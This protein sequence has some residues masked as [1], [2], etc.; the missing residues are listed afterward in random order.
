MTPGSS[1]VLVVG[2][3]NV[4]GS[5][6]R[7]WTTKT[8]IAD[9][10]NELSDQLGGCVW[11]SQI[12]EEWSGELSRGASEEVGRPDPSKVRVVAV[13]LDGGGLASLWL[14]L[15]RELLRSRYAIF[16]LPASLKLVPVLPLA[17]L[18]VRRMA[19]YVAGDF[20][21]LLE[22]E[23][24]GRRTLRGRVYRSAFRTAIAVSHRV[25]ARGRYLAAVSRR[26][27][28]HVFETVPLAHLHGGKSPP[29]SDPAS[30]QVR[31]VLYMGLVARSKGLGDLLLA[32]RELMGRRQEP[33]VRLDV[34]G[35]GPD[36]E[37][38][39]A[40][41]GELG[42]L[43]CVDFR[44]WVADPDDIDRF[45]TRAHVVVVPSSTHPEG[46]PRV[47]DE[48]LVRSVPVVATRIAGIPDEF[49]EDEVSLVDP[50]APAQLARAIEE[51]LFDADVRRRYVEGAGRRRGDWA[52]FTSA[53]RQHAEI[54]TGAVA[55][56]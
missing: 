40:Q 49:R 53:G 27:N 37:S 38:L 55:P 39:R 29:C 11:I 42:L 23:A 22:S 18:L 34:L 14:L 43:G 5:A 17:R 30:D 56:G 45:L 6:D 46:V 8:P 4:R 12:S 19:V 16:F 54:L 9:Y 3:G 13:D 35:E 41:A 25:I 7:G 26:Y 31:R 10:L 2:G 21:R 28:R 51:V 48:A 20:E 15:L 1:R 44:G 32:M 36:L 33:Q 52:G 24:G 47:I 50:G